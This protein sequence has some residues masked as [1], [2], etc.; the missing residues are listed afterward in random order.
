MII[1]INP[2]DTL[3]FKDG[4]PFSLGEETWADGIFPPP[5]SVIYGALRSAFFAQQ[6]QSIALANEAGDRSR[7]LEIKQIS[8]VAK[9]MQIYPLP[10]DLAHAK[11]EAGS[12][13]EE[14]EYEVF[15]LER[16]P[17]NYM[18]SL[19]GVMKDNGSQQPLK[20]FLSPP[21]DKSIE[22]LEGGYF[23]R[24]SLQ[25]YLGGNE[26]NFPAYKIDDYLKREPKVGI[27]RDDHTRTTQEARLYRV[28]MQRLKD[29][30]F[31]VEFENLKLSEEG[32]LKL[33]GEG[34]AVSYKTDQFPAVEQP[35]L[36]G[37]Q[38]KLYLA[39]PGL[40]TNGWLPGWINPKTLTGKYPGTNIEVQLIAAGVGKPLFIGG[41]DM[42]QQKPKEMRKAV[43]AGSV[44]YFEVLGEVPEDQLRTLRPTLFCDY[45]D[46]I[47][48]GFG[49]THLGVVV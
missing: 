28:G 3:F 25:S 1:D 19:S 23:S 32:F 21:N 10:L 9:G 47:K 33:G 18:S 40:L 45:E 35:E 26:K 24:V 34:K 17:N 49:I 8:I 42:K 16:K 43:P 11:D 4:K 6:N 14:K 5:P 48:E 31:I 22:I 38:F 36:Q 44:Y 37:K 2:L 20:Y 46:R 7:G 12:S 15:F 29:V 39:T 27:A 30:H 13:D 41:F